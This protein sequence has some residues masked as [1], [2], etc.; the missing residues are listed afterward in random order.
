MIPN[1]EQMVVEGQGKLI[2]RRTKTAGKDYDR[3]F[4]YVPTEVARDGL[5]PFKEGDKLTLKIDAKNKRLVVQKASAQDVR[6]IK[7]RG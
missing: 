6:K 4:I 2:N 7:N 1:S 5:F 3:F